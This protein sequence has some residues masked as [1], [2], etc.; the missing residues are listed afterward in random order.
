MYKIRT[1]N[2]I[3]QKGLDV[4]D[5]Q[6]F[7][8]SDSEEN[9][10]AILLRSQ[11]LTTEL[12]PNSV[13]AI[14]RA[15]AGVNNVPVEACTNNNIVVFNAPGANANAVKELVL[16]AMLIG[17]RNIHKGLMFSNSLSSNSGNLHEIVEN[18]KS[19]FKG[20]ELRG[21]SLGIIG[22][23]AIGVHVANAAVALG[24]KVEGYDPF[25]SVN[26]A[27]D[28]SRSVKHA[29]NLKSML[30]K[31]DFITIHMPLSE[32]TEGFVNA[33]LISEIKKGSILLNFSR[34]EIVDTDAILA[35]LESNK[36]A[37]YINDFPNAKLLSNENN[38]SLPHL[39]AST[40]EAEVNCSIMVAEQISDYILNGNISNSVNFP[41]C[42]M[43][44]T[45]K[46]RIAVINE[47]KPNMVGQITKILADLNV[48]IS[49]MMNKSRNEIAYTLVDT[50]DDIPSSVIKAIKNIDGVRSVRLF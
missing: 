30:S 37:S 34:E 12:I 46:H 21:K 18:E 47:N 23:G 28:L 41:N 43:E 10:D 22:L 39:G 49:E 16:G 42:A 35:A 19:K 48:N 38:I 50:N 14:G 20:I 32:K 40:K 26:R 7:E 13:I 5:K 17:A 31:S 29:E 36:L 11:K 9:A 45:G 15:G 44:K 4:F 1:F 27:W 3:A 2:K 24:M 25:I 6:L 33:G 8:I